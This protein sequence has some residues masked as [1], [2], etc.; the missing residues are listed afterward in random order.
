[1]TA[2]VIVSARAQF[3]KA[4]TCYAH[5]DVEYFKVVSCATTWTMSDLVLLKI[6]QIFLNIKKELLLHSTRTFARQDNRCK[7]RQ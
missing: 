2:N 4:K 7:R 3:R 1:M 5:L 6:G